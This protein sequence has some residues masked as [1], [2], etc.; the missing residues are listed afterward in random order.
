ML[1]STP[2]AHAQGL[3]AIT[4]LL[5]YHRPGLAARLYMIPIA[6]A[7]LAQAE[8]RDGKGGV[9]CKE[10]PAA[11]PARLYPIFLFCE[12]TASLLGLEEDAEARV[13]KA[14]QR[15]EMALRIHGSGVSEALLPESATMVVSPWG[16]LDPPR[17]AAASGAGGVD[18]GCLPIFSPQQQQPLSPSV[19]ITV[20][21]VV[22][23]R[24]TVHLLPTPP[25]APLLASLRLL[26]D[27]FGLHLTPGE[28]LQEGH[29]FFQAWALAFL[30]SH[31]QSGVVRERVAATIA[32]RGELMEEAAES[33]RRALG[34]GTAKDHLLRVSNDMTL[35]GGQLEVQAAA[36]FENV[37][38]SIFDVDMQRLSTLAPPADSPL[39]AAREA[40]LLHHE[41]AYWLLTPQA[42]SEGEMDTTLAQALATT[43]AM[44]GAGS[45]DLDASMASASQRM[46]EL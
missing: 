25:P 2:A 29:D 33:V 23:G 45:V 9:H 5:R 31:E 17:P 4:T 30:G 21:R 42:A 16:N 39:P 18:G 24:G 46:S 28:T 44:G 8:L 27:Y 15:L 19:G 38:V 11:A 7:E 26:N 36:I 14:L 1:A 20:R 22:P 40:A 12:P 34:G 32:G 10:G 6:K 35:S 41:G 3:A 13:E 37:R 43:L